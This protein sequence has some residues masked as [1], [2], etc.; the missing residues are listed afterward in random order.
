MSPKPTGTARC[1]PKSSPETLPF[2][3][4]SAGSSG[5]FDIELVYVHPRALTVAQKALVRQAA[6]R[7]EEVIVGDLPNVN[8]GS[9]PINEWIGSPMNATNPGQRRS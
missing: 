5:A 8:F 1:R 6:D 9:N 4:D 3:G 7:W 2:C